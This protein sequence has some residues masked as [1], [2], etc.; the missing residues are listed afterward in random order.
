MR[1]NTVLEIIHT[2]KR[3]TTMLCFAFILDTHNLFRTFFDFRTCCMKQ[4]LRS[5]RLFKYYEINTSTMGKLKWFILFQEN[6]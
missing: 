5:L 3:N 6:T 1:N 4:P 2:I